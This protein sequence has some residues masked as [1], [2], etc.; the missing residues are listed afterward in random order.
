MV[1][2]KKRCEHEEAT[3]GLALCNKQQEEHNAPSFRVVCERT[4]VLAIKEEE[5]TEL[6]LALVVNLRTLVGNKVEEE[7]V[8]AGVLLVRHVNEREH[9]PVA[10]IALPDS[11]KQKHIQPALVIAIPPVGEEYEEGH[12]EGIALPTPARHRQIDHK[13]NSNHQF[14]W[15]AG[16]AKE[17]EQDGNMEL[18][19]S[20]VNVQEYEE[21]QP[22]HLR[23][24]A[25]VEEE[26][27]Q[28]PSL[29]ILLST[30]VTAWPTQHGPLLVSVPVAAPRS[31]QSHAGRDTPRL[32]IYID[33]ILHCS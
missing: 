27:Q 25:R 13:Q 4:L 15:S 8:T 10:I 9:S 30:V 29:L 11:P 17:Y 16:V 31:V 14:S 2:D 7:V 21:V 26:L 5:Y 23:P 28:A 19:C 22:Q 12:V 1:V 3:R 33:L 24:P 18:I 20:L 6:L 32:P